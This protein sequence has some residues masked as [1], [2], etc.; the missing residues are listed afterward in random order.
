MAVAELLG[1]IVGVML[2]LI[3]AYLLVGSVIYTAETVAYAQ[4]DNTLQQEARLGTNFEL[5]YVVP[6]SP[7]PNEFTI[8]FKNTGSEIIRDFSHM[9]IFTYEGTGD[10]KY[11][12]PETCP[13]VEESWCVASNPKMLDPGDEMSITVFSNINSNIRIV[14]GNGVYRDAQSP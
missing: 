10:F 4:K 13:I 5:T 8:T 6:S 12:T 2:L 11:L 9:D 3:T 14:T 7:S 1:A